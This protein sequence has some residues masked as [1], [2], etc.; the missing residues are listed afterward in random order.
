MLSPTALVDVLSDWALAFATALGS[1]LLALGGAV[2]KNHRRSKQNERDLQ[3][4]DNPNHEGVLEISKQ[5]GE[6]ID[7]LADRMDEQ[8]EHLLDRFEELNGGD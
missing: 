5:N 8:H 3:G 7:E 2:G 6:K 4:T 1:G